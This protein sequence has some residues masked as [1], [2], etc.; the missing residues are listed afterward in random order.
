MGAPRKFDWDEAARLY[1]TGLTYEEIAEAL[2]VSSSAVWL[3]LNP[4]ARARGDA[5]KWQWQREARCPDCGAQ[6]TRTHIGADSRCK[7]CAALARATSVRATE[8][9]CMTCRE[10]KPDEEFPSNRAATKVRRGRH[11]QCR[12]C[13]TVARRD[14]RARNREADNAYSREYK[15][16]RRRAA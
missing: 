15:R 1:E 16:R 14:H 7:R 6:T 13:Q 12:I 8:L 3:A 4:E 10:W 5:R 2:G 11:R 9:R